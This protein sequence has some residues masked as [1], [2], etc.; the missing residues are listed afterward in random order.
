[1]TSRYDLQTRL[2]DLNPDWTTTSYGFGPDADEFIQEE[3]VERFHVAPCRTC[4]GRLKPDVVFF[5]DT[6][7]RIKVR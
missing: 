7:R 5:G 1:M 3:D 6:V 2:D 4:G